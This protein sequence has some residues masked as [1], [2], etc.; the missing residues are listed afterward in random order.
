MKVTKGIRHKTEC[1]HSQKKGV[2]EDLPR[3]EKEKG[4]KVPKKEAKIPRNPKR[5]QETQNDLWSEKKGGILNPE[6]QK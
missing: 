5:D 3:T 2:G 6:T 1:G 4:V